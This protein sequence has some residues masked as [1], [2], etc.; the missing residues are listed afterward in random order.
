MALCELLVHV[1][2]A[3]VPSVV[4][5]SVDARGIG[6]APHIVLEE[7]EERV[8][9]DVVVLVVGAARGGH[10]ADGHLLAGQWGGDSLAAAGLGRAAVA[11]AHGGSNPG[12]VDVV[13]EAAEGGDDAAAAA[14]GLELAVR[15]DV[16]LHRSAVRHQNKTLLFEQAVRQRPESITIVLGRRCALHRAPSFR[17][18]RRGRPHTCNQPKTGREPLPEGQ[19]RHMTCGGVL[20]GARPEG[21]RDGTIGLGARQPPFSWPW[22][23]REARSNPRRRLTRRRGRSYTSTRP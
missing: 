7:P 1:D 20:H 17:V 13:G 5:D 9:D 23:A 8:A 4:N 18:P 2:I 6:G 22:P 14:P 12:E 21:L 19:S 10:E 3:G 16:V 15:A 11:F